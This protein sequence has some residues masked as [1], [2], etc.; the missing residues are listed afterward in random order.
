MSSTLIIARREFRSNFDS[1]IGYVV[2]CLSLIGVGLFFFRD[3]WTINRA[4]INGLFTWLP[5][6]F[7]FPI[8]PAVTMRLFAEEKRTGTIELLIT[9]P[10]RDLDV[11]LGKFLATVGL[12]GVLLLL[13]LT[14]PLFIARLGTL[15]SGPIWVGYF[16]LLLEAAAGIAIGLYASSITENQIVAF[17]ITFTALV[18]LTAIDYLGAAAGGVLGDIFAFVSFQRRLAPFGRGLL[19][20]RNVVFFLSVASFFLMLTV[21]SLES[22]KWK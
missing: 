21:R 3:Y 16:G 9:M 17:M 20:L 1:P 18:L 15:D 11:V 10:V 4:S 19:D 12:V 5:W 7:V 13:T 6:A 8:I 2:I 14:Y 22:R